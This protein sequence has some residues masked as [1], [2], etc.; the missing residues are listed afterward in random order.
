MN[1]GSV[2]VNTMKGRGIRSK[3]EIMTNAGVNVKNQMIEIVDRDDYIWNSSTCN[4]ECNN[5]FKVGGY[6]DIKL[7][8]CQMM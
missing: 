6:L 7:C 8:K 4:F 2:N 3:N 1:R 5:A